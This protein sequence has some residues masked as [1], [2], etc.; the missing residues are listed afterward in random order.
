M[1]YEIKRDKLRRK[2]YVI[3]NYLV[4]SKKNPHGCSGIGLVEGF[5]SYSRINNTFINFVQ[6]RYRNHETQF[7][8]LMWFLEIRKYYY[9]STTISFFFLLLSSV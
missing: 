9:C 5:D 8:D 3:D 7:W 1:T 2:K 4:S 6:C